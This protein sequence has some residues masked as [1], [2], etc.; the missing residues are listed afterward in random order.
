MLKELRSV[1]LVHYALLP[2]EQLKYVQL[3][4]IIKKHIQDMQHPH[5][6][7]CD[8]DFELNAKLLLAFVWISVMDW[9]LVHLIKIK[10][11]FFTTTF[12][13]LL[14]ENQQWGV[15]NILPHYL[16]LKVIIKKWYFYHSQAIPRREFQN[17]PLLII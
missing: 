9:L 15:E 1:L 14:I 6:I 8:S 2:N 12:S 16:S 10:E 13:I 5:K 4:N 3:F 7:N 17:S 11:F